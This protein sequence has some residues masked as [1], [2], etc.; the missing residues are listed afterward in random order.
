ML[1]PTKS[2]QGTGSAAISWCGANMAR[3][4]EYGGGGGA[5]DSGGNGG[6]DLFGRGGGGEAREDEDGG[7][8]SSG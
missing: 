4:Y 3:Q 6:G 1:S 7:D 5:G 8:V 2:W